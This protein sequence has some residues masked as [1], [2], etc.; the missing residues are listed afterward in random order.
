MK[1]R[2]T[3]EELLQTPKRKRSGSAKKKKKVSISLSNKKATKKRLNDENVE[4]VL[5]VRSD[6]KKSKDPVL[7]LKYPIRTN[8]KEVSM[9]L[10]LS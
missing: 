10:I 6:K 7:M 4:P 2:M 5:R 8:Q 1:P 9:T 3:L